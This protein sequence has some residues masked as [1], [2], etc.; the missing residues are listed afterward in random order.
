MSSKVDIA[1]QALTR[2]G[3]NRIISFDDDTTE[4]DVMN[5]TYEPT[6]R[7]FLRSYPW[8]CASRR[9]K[10]AQLAEPPVNEYK[11]A[12]ALPEDSIKI[13][14]VFA[15]DYLLVREGSERSEFRIEGKKL[16][17]NHTNIIVLYTYDINESLM[18]AHVERAFVAKLAADCCYPIQ[19][20][21][22][23]QQTWIQLA[24][25]EM[26]EARTTDNLESGTEIFTTSRLNNVRG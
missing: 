21:P 18:D 5:V 6:K 2:L 11:Y 14:D 4:A 10:L 26:V 19:G 1:N 17:T 23:N 13:Y 16:L 15:G 8:N 25:L 3:A 24:E 22:G 7:A 20:S 12:F 9:A